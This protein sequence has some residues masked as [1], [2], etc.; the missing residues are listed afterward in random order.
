MCIVFCI[1][2]G[3]FLQII[4]NTIGHCSGWSSR[5]QEAWFLACDQ[6]GS[7]IESAGGVLLGDLVGADLSPGPSPWRHTC[8]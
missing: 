1:S 8:C 5:Q 4:Y 7:R 3:L 6:A 2:F